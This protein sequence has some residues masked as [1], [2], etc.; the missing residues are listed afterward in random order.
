M[1]CHAPISDRLC[2]Q[3]DALNAYFNSEP[4]DWVYVN[5]GKRRTVDKLKREKVQKIRKML[6]DDLRLSYMFL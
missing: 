4:T 5:A 1:T 2:E 3:W 6:D